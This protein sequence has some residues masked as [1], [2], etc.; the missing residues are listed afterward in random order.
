MI[1]QGKYSFDI[2]FSIMGYIICILSEIMYCTFD[3]KS[4]QVIEW[5]QRTSFNPFMAGHTSVWFNIWTCWWHSSCRYQVNISS[6]FSNNSD[7]N[8]SELLENLE[9]MFFV[10]D[11]RVW[12]PGLQSVKKHETQYSVVEDLSWLLL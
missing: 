11:S 1:S 5:C 3:D 2:V 12:I 8:S 6:I 4:K 9:E 10:T 7:A